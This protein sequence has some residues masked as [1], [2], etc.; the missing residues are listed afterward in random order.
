MLT[1][2]SICGLIFAVAIAIFVFLFRRL[3]SSHAQAPTPEWVRG[4]AP[5]QYRPME[6]LLTDADFR[7]LR[8]FPGTGER[9]AR[10]LRS[11]RRRIF[12][13]YLRALDRDFGR[14]CAGLRCVVATAGEDR[15]EL[16][17]LVMRQ[18]VAF[19][20]AML[21]VELR[22]ALH[23]AGLGAVDARQLLGCFDRL[24]AEL[25]MLNAEPAASAA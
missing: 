7:F 24:G 5:Q 8:S 20:V 3:L 6:R 17:T 15:S 11:E 22:L 4:L 14:V 13:G 19:G 9:V 25:R 23:A 2:L 18:Q 1:L 10:K 21:R 12:R 16:A